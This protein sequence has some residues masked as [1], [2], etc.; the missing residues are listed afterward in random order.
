M[1]T[2]RVLEAADQEALMRFLETH[3]DTTM[4]LR[5][6]AMQAGV[7]DHGVRP[8][9]TYVAAFD[10]DAVV[11][12]AGLFWNGALIME[13][14]T[15]LPEI[16]RTAVRAA[17]R[18][19]TGLLGAHAQ[20]QEAR[21][22]L[23]LENVATGHDG[24]EPLFRL[25]LDRLKV[26]PALEDG[27][28]ACRRAEPRDLETMVVWGRAYHV[29]ALNEDDG[30][31]LEV[32]VRENMETRIARGRGWV[33]AR[34]DELVAT[35]AFNTTTPDCVQVGGVYTPPEL[36]ANGYA[37]AAVAGSLLDARAEG[38][39]RSILFTPEDNLAAQ[40]CYLGLG[41]EIVGDYALVTFRDEQ[42]PAL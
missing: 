10:G 29:E 4:F 17:P 25:E 40:A 12:A 27:T 22:A 38:H 28:L 30:P 26:P 19:V 41:Y 1:E 16:V 34:D 18:G 15:R 11:A 32:R 37:R 14:P 9:G 3:P 13:A 7:V 33:L 31:E 2:V 21:G 24:R 39:V 8:Q 35:T 5:G 20:V 23:G 42:H 36:R 6:N